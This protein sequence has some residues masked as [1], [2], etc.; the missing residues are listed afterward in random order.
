MRCHIRLSMILMMIL[1]IVSCTMDNTEN[2]ANVDSG[3]NPANNKISSLQAVIDDSKDGDT[4]NLS[5]YAITDYNAVVNKS[6]TISGSSTNLNNAMLTVGGD[7]NNVSI[8]GITNASVT[9]DKSLANGSLKISGSSLSSL[10]IQGGGWNSIYL[11]NGSSVEDVIL[12]KKL[13]SDEDQY[14]RL[15]ADNTTSVENLVVKQSAILAAESIITADNIKNVTFSIDESSDAVA[16]A[17]GANIS[18]DKDN[19]LVCVTFIDSDESADLMK[20]FVRKSDES[21]IITPKFFVAAFERLVR[22]LDDDTKTAMLMQFEDVI[23]V[24]LIGDVELYVE[25]LDT[26][27]SESS[28]ASDGSSSSDSSSSDSSTSSSDSSSSDSSTSS[29]DS[30]SSDSSSSSSD[31]SL[32]DSSSS[33]SSSDS[34]ASESSSSDDSSSGSESGE[35]LTCVIRYTGDMTVDMTVDYGKPFTICDWNIVYTAEPAGKKFLGWNTTGDKNG[36]T[37]SVG[38]EVANTAAPGSVTVLYPVWDYKTY[39][40]KYFDGSMDIS[41]EFDPMSFTINDDVSLKPAQ[42][43][44][45]IFAGWYRNSTD[46]ESIS[47]W[48]AGDVTAD[49]DLT[50]K[51]TPITYT[52]RYHIG[53]GNGTDETTDQQFIYDTEQSL[54]PNRFE[55]DNWVFMGWSRTLQS[56]PGEEVLV[57]Y[58]DCDYIDEPLADEPDV[59]VDLYAVWD[60]AWIVY[61][62]LSYSKEY[63][64]NLT[65]LPIGVALECDSTGKPAKIIATQDVTNTLG[66]PTS[67]QWAIKTTQTNLNT[68]E[69]DGYANTQSILNTS[70]TFGINYP[71]FGSLS[72]LNMYSSNVKLYIPAKNEL[73]TLHDN[74]AKVNASLSA[75]GGTLISEQ[76]YW[77]STQTDDTSKA[78]AVEMATGQTAETTLTEKK[79][80]RPFALITQ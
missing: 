60:R 63:I 62:D 49:I 11:Q 46:T 7:N 10:N 28:S 64:Y 20:M 4:I 17:V 27:N 65:N 43:T 47:G 19:S 69:Y 6:L 80:V 78:Y 48:S 45:Y 42:K 36:V 59:I 21:S 52:V 71:L 9:A 5:Q 41:D 61:A 12:N 77:S 51:W 70:S 14:V 54:D 16:F 33:S 29:S 53:A 34:S 3:L 37:Y 15:V 35:H 25:G 56:A 30:S 73:L 32:S 44:G 38:Q 68:T 72:A 75:L 74:L 67:Y 26:D 8:S 22:P 76:T 79:A 18:F 24:S 66:Q 2:A 55:V 50:A 23:G 58:E 39:S 57:E 13:T 31:S 40:I 1:M